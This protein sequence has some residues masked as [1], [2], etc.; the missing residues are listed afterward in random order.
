M[1][2]QRI[3][4]NAVLLAADPVKCVLCK[5]E[6]PIYVLPALMSVDVVPFDV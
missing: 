5:T 4:T 2:F 1:P 3:G 6:S